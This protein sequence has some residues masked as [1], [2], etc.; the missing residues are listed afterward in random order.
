M[1]K[2]QVGDSG[3]EFYTLSDNDSKV[4]RLVKQFAKTEDE[5]NWLMVYA[6]FRPDL[7]FT[8][9]MGVLQSLEKKLGGERTSTLAHSLYDTI[10]LQ[11]NYP[12]LCIKSNINILS[13]SYDGDHGESRNDKSIVTYEFQWRFGPGPGQRKWSK[14][15]EVFM[16]EWSHPVLA[17]N[18]YQHVQEMRDLIE[19]KTGDKDS[20]DK[21]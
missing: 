11:S 6:G 1:E 4:Y 21:R 5:L 9:S 16:G 2:I 19:Y 13:I 17:M 10:A 7:S 12:A 18:V 8:E 15:T 20:E 14:M 3:P